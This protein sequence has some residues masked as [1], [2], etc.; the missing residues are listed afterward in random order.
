MLALLPNDSPA[1]S[2]SPEFRC[3]QC[4]QYKLSDEYGTRKRSDRYGQKGDRLSL[5]LSCG[6]RNSANRK[7]GRIEDS[8]DHPVKRRAI[9]HVISPSELTAVLVELAPAAEIDDYWRVSVDGMSLTDRE[10]ANHLASL[11]WKAIRYRFR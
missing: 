6:A 5:C 7:R 2:T 3:S 9:Q 8:P 10:V 11:V 4:N 1:M